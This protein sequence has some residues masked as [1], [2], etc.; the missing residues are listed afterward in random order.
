LVDLLIKKMIYFTA[1][2]SA[3]VDLDDEDGSCDFEWGIISACR[4]LGDLKSEKAATPLVEVLDLV[5]DDCNSYLHNAAMLALVGMGVSA[6]DATY[7]K[8][9]RDRNDPESAS[10]WIWVLSR[11][12]IKNDKIYHA[13]L[14]LASTDSA[15]AVI[16]MGDYG[17]RK[18]LPVAEEIVGRFADYLNDNRIDPFLRGARYEDPKIMAYLNSRESLVILRDGISIDDPKYGVKVEA[19]D[20][21]LLRHSDFSVYQQV[22][23]GR[24]KPCPCGSGKKYKKCCGRN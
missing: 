22:R 18:L 14:D 12:G 4:F 11:L 8:Y 1:N 7:R 24:N 16:L 5:V 13:L 2:F 17:D 19:L 15:E 9:E 23:V 21:E 20:R 10:A 6:F 3:I